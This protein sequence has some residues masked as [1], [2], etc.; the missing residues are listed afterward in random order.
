MPPVT[1]EWAAVRIFDVAEEPAHAALA[2]PPWQNGEGVQIRSKEQIRFRNVGK[3]RNGGGI[4]RNAAFHRV[5]QL[6]GH[7]GNVLLYAE[8]IAEG[9]ANELDVVFFYELHKLR[10]GVAHG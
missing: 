6:A 3:A 4:K 1:L 9:Q 10:K 7:D 8:H 5:G 2:G